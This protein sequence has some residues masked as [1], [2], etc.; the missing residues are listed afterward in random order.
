MRTT[1]RALLPFLLP[2]LLQAVVPLSIAVF[3][4]S[5]VAQSVAPGN[6]R[7]AIDAAVADPQRPEADRARDATRKPADCLA[8]AGLKAG[9]H[10]VEL[11]PGGGYFTRIFSV[12]VGSS[13]HVFAVAQPKSPSAAADAPEPA[14]RVQAIAADAHYANVSVVV[15]RLSQPSLPH[16]VDLVWTSQNYH[17]LHNVPDLDIAAFNKAVFDALKPGGTYIVLDHAAQAGSGARD[18]KTLHR[19]DADAVKKEV[20]AAGFELVAQSDLL[21]NPAD[22]HTSAVFDPSI[23]GKTDQ[24]LIKFRRPAE[25]AR[26]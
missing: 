24:F 5:A 7:P 9:D 23:R 20:L 15:Q 8:F 21:R 1:G 12:V 13:G 22:P 2:L 14:A 17:D 3:P 26:R 18:T 25:A 4:L 16:P 11:L 10:V 19:I 6:S